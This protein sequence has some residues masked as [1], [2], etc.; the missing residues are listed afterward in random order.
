MSNALVYSHGLPSGQIWYHAKDYY[1]HF[2]N[3]NFMGRIMVPIGRT[4]GR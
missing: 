2:A 4:K 3:L 1:P